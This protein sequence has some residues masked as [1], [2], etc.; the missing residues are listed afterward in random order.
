MPSAWYKTPKDVL[1]FSF[2]SVQISGD[3]TIE[4]LKEVIKKAEFNN[5]SVEDI[6]LEMVEIPYNH[7]DIINFFHDNLFGEKLLENKYIKDY[8]ADAP[9]EGNIHILV[10]PPRRVIFIP[11]IGAPQVM[12]R[13]EGKFKEMIGCERTEIHSI[14]SGLPGYELSIYTDEIGSLK[15]LPKNDLASCLYYGGKCDQEPGIRVPSC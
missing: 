7:E 3:K 1:S 11:V 14:L 12:V 6:S 9:P 10:K 15:N 8:W 4:E 5:F 13:P 2:F